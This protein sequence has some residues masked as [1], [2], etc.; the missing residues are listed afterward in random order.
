MT[1][2][3]LSKDIIG[4]EVKAG[5]S[6][7]SKDLQG[8]HRLGKVAGKHFKRGIVLHDGERLLP[9]GNKITSAPVSSLWS[10]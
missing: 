4:V 7:T 9:L 2:Q 10:D 1:L 8:L 5:A 3:A 6:L